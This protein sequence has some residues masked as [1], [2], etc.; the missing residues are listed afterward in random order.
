MN[1]IKAGLVGLAFLGAVGGVTYIAEDFTYS[2]G[3]RRGV[4]TKL[5][6]KGIIFK[7]WEGQLAM[8][9]VSQGGS[10]NTSGANATVSNTF[11]FSVTDQEVIQE[12]KDA[13]DAG[14]PVR[15]EYEQKLFPW[16]TERK[17]EY[18]IVDVVPVEGGQTNSAPVVIAP[19]R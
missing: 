12:L 13:L 6:K 2:E 7:T 19:R 15:L 4:V 8:Q 11:N 18:E 10:L 16:W 1:K 9:N 5:S 17:T 14:E 3:D